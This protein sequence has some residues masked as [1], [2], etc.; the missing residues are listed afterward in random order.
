MLG[1]DIERM[2]GAIVDAKLKHYCAEV[3]V[4]MHGQYKFETYLDRYCDDLAARLTLGVYSLGEAS[5]VVAET[6]EFRV[7]AT[8]WDACKEHFAARWWMRPIVK[9]HTVKYR[10]LSKTVREE[11]TATALLPDVPI[12]GNRY[13]IRFAMTGGMRPQPKPRLGLCHRCGFPVQE[14][15]P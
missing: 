13:A 9:R 14:F 12:Q 8:W 7:P 4:P 1:G 3:R 6:V 5:R 11:V 15:E 10:T 2:F